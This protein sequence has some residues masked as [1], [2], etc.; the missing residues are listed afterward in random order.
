MEN[1]QIILRTA[2]IEDLDLLNK[3]DNE[4]HVIESDPNDDWNWEEELLQDPEW[5]QQLIAELDG[6]PIGFV[7]IIDPHLEDSHYWGDCSPN[8]RAIDIWIGEKD[9][10]DQGFGSE[11]MRLAIDLCFEDLHVTEIWIDPLLSN[12]RAHKFY[13]R[14]GFKP[15]EIRWFGQDECLVHVLQRSDYAS[16]SA[17]RNL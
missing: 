9:F 10:L 3:W 6:K 7:H 15:I 2:T 12:T 13:Q 14:L 17:V 4:E 1:N 8:L 11:M 16:T 5:R